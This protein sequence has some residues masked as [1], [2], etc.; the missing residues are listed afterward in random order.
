MAFSEEFFHFREKKDMQFGNW[1]TKKLKFAWC[2]VLVKS[3]AYSD[4]CI[5]SVLLNRAEQ[6]NNETKYRRTKNFFHK[7]AY[8]IREI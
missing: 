6:L 2:L 3:R 5:I 4:L 8:S 1:R 7:R